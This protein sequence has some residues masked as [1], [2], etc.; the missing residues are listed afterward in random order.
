M[1]LR[2]WVLIIALVSGSVLFADS[3]FA[4]DVTR[5]PRYHP[6]HSANIVGAFGSVY[7]D[8]LRIR[9]QLGLD[10]SFTEQQQELLKE[11]MKVVMQRALKEPVISCAFKQA[12]KNLPES[13]EIFV[14]QMLSA[15]ALIQNQETLFPAFVFVGRFWDD[16]KTVGIAYQDLF[17]DTEFPFPGYTH[18]HYL[19][20]AINSDFLGNSTGYRFGNDVNYW[21]G[22]LA[23]EFLHNLGYGHP[24]GYER[25]FIR[26]YE[27]CLRNDGLEQA[28]IEDEVFDRVVEKEVEKDL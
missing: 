21:A 4:R 5:Y 2:V 11:A 25:S 22:V 18:R 27:V 12:S 9:T 15:L 14:E 8:V 19:H 7:D 13:K 6:R 1:K 10:S 26:E 3:V 16:P 24:T 28:P 17:Y 20:V 23:H